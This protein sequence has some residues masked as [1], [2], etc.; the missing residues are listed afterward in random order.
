MSISLILIAVIS[1]IVIAGVAYLYV[2]KNDDLNEKKKSMILVIVGTVI[3]LSFL[4]TTFKHRDL[5]FKSSHYSQGSL[6]ISK[7]FF[8]GKCVFEAPVKYDQSL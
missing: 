4:V 2:S 3:F 6:D 7:V 8:G 1:L 5:G